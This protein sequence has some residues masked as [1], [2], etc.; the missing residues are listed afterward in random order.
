MI[1]EE[2]II[3]K[4]QLQYTL[5]M[6]QTAHPLSS[7]SSQDGVSMDSVVPNMRLEDADFVGRIATESFRDKLAWC[8]GET[9]EDTIFFFSIFPDLQL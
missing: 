9:K 7:S 8:M 6:T 5:T 3:H 2:L 1:H 4:H